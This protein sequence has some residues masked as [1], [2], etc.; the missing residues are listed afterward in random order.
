MI[1][2][3]IHDSKWLKDRGIPRNKTILDE[4]IKVPIVYNS[5]TLTDRQQGRMITLEEY[6]QD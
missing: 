1:D 5:E 6:D 3:P 4:C 2:K